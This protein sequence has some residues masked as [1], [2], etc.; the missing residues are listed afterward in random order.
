MAS[1][2]QSCTG[3][4]L[5]KAQQVLLCAFQLYFIKVSNKRCRTAAELG[6][7]WWEGALL[8]TQLHTQMA[9]SKVAR[10]RHSYYIKPHKDSNVTL[11]FSSFEHVGGILTVISRVFSSFFGPL[12][13]SRKADE[14]SGVK[15]KWCGCFM[16]ILETPVDAGLWG[17]SKKA[18]KDEERARRAAD[19]VGTTQAR[20]FPD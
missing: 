15:I 19:G 18:K 7:F 14:A 5:L 13:N 11:M 4:V 9:I 10:L 3:G 8:S 6:H 16:M 20:L 12:A 17:G 2:F 1:A